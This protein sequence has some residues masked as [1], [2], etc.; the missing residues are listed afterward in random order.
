LQLAILGIPSKP[1]PIDMDKLV[2]KGLTMK[3]I[4]GREMFETWYKMRNMLVGGL[5]ARLSPVITHRYKFEEFQVCLLACRLALHACIMPFACVP[6][7]SAEHVL[8]VD[9]VVSCTVAEYSLCMIQAGFDVMRSGQSGK[10]V[11]DF[12]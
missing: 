12:E 5:A 11:L 2:F 1:F 9:V 3:G 10:V 8:T 4:Y 7:W 6:L